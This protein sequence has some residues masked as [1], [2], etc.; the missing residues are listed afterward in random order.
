MDMNSGKSMDDILDS[1]RRIVHE[2]ETGEADPKQDAARAETHK[3]EASGMNTLV[4][5]R[6]M[7]VDEGANLDE[8]ATLNLSQAEK[9]SDDEIEAIA[10]L[11]LGAAA[12]TEAEDAREAVASLRIDRSPEKTEEQD[13][14][15]AFDAALTGDDL[16]EDFADG[17]EDEP[18]DVSE[19]GHRTAADAVEDGAE[20]TAAAS[21]APGDRDEY[22]FVIPPAE[23]PFAKKSNNE[24]KPREAGDFSLRLNRTTPEEAAPASAEPATAASKKRE[25]TTL[26]GADSAAGP[27]PAGH[28]AAQSAPESRGEIERIV[29]SAVREELSGALG[30]KITRNIR[31]MVRSEIQRVMETKQI[32]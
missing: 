24:P 27:S 20:A 29:R 17:F 19:Y 21:D 18:E 12:E 26:H 6:E 3:R 14:I 7:R 10:S 2:E 13:E 30:D 16:T 25:E 28:A 1:I 31:G 5:T 32:K 23:S 22:G 15:A 11:R 4:L 9:V 8:D